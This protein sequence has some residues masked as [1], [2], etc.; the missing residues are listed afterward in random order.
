MEIGNLARR[1]RSRSGW[2]GCRRLRC[3]GCSAGAPSTS[4]RFRHHRGNRLPH[5]VIVVD[6]TSMVSLTMMARLLEAVRPETRLILVGD[7][8]QLTSVE[9]GAVLAD[10]VDGLSDRADARVAALQTSHR[11]GE[12]IGE[13]AAAIRVGDADRVVEVLRAGGEHIELIEADNPAPHLR[14]VVVPHALG[15]DGRGCWATARR[16]WRRWTSTGCCVR[17]DADRSGLRHWNRQVERWLMEATGE[18]IWSPW[19]AGRPVLVTSNDYGLRLFNGD[20]GL[21]VLQDGALRAV[22]A[23]A[24][25]PLTFATSRLADVETMHAMTIHKI[26]GS[27]ARDVTVLLPPEES[28]LL[29]RELFYTAVT[30][31]KEKIRVVGQES[32]VRAAVQRRAIRASGLGRRLQTGD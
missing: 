27:Q 26:Q 14:K 23:S 21:T 7:P 11:F 25:D 4:S 6:E 16:R 3:T 32:S 10:L 15:C 20:T 12:S 18:P 28:R 1:R 5:D 29:T 30:R 17:T 19:Y 2:Q 9:A 24:A 8:D 31:A 13:L 22:I